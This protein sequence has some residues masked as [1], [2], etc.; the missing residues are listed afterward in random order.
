MQ[1]TSRWIGLV[2]LVVVAMA[3]CSSAPGFQ[4][5]AADGIARRVTVYY[6]T[7]RAATSREPGEVTYG[8]KRAYLT[9]SEP[10]QLGVCK[11]EIRRER[12]HDKKS[13][14]PKSSSPL[15]QLMSVSTVERHEFYGRLRDM[16][17]NA[18]TNETFVFVHGFNNT[19][20]EA[21]TRTAE[22]WYDMGFRGPPI[23][24]SWPS[25]GGVFG[26]FADGATIEWTSANLKDFLRQLAKET[27][28][29]KLGAREP[30]RIHLI[31]HSMGCRA[32]L[33]ALALIADELESDE[34]PIFCDV[35][36]AAPDVDGDV[37]RDVIAP[38]LMRNPVAE[39]YTLYA[40]GA[41]KALHVSETLQVYPRAG[42]SVSRNGVHEQPEFDAI[43]ISAVHEKAKGMRHD[44]FISEP[45]VLRDM[46]EILMRGNRAPGSGR[47]ELVRDESM[48]GDSWVMVES[49]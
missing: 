43:D 26:Y 41:D 28:A 44:Y 40:S 11:V 22:L 25:R 39:H 6:A 21:A 45:A 29:S 35:I 4:G 20:E 16:M 33:G 19:F 17:W 37:F 3:G 42:S 23:M 7:D 47:R 10:Y 24:Y 12:N 34:R 32:M 18:G 31:A 30:A 13:P 5:V 9:G 49:D 27:D 15:V 36:V 46:I 14:L 8:W 2:G 1:R 48:P 38:R